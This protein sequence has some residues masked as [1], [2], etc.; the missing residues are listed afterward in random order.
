MLALQLTDEQA[1]EV[2]LYVEK[3]L[4]EQNVF[5]THIIKETCH[6]SVLPD[7]ESIFFFVQ[8]YIEAIDNG[9]LENYFVSDISL[10]FDFLQNFL[11]CY[12][13]A[14]GDVYFTQLLKNIASG[15]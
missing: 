5:L 4:T 10:L 15:K 7:N 9:E 11:N 6:I 1:S 13:G 2:F 14:V 12:F 3:L 8:E